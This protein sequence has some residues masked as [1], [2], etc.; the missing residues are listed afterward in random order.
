MGLTLITA[1]E[2]FTNPWDL[3]FTVGEEVGGGKFA[4]GIFRGPGHQGKVLLTTQ[5]FAE[6]LEEVVEA[7]NGVLQ[8][9]CKAVTEEFESK[10]SLASQYLNPDGQEIH[11]SKVLNQEIISWVLEGL[12]HGQEA[13]TNEMFATP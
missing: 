5:P 6:T 8:S 2:I 1:L 11:Q 10:Q 12:R 4:F 9:I 7:V 3:V 13:C